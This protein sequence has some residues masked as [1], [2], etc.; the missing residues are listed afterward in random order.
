MRSWKAGEKFGL[1][2]AVRQQGT[3]ER[4]GR[5][6][7]KTWLY[8]CDCGGEKVAI[9]CVV[10]SGKITSCGCVSKKKKDL[11]GMVFGRWT[12]IKE[13]AVRSNSHVCWECRCDCGSV[14]GDVIGIHLF[15]GFSKSCGCLVG[16]SHGMAGTHEYWTWSKMIDRCTNP[17]NKVFEHYGGRG[18]AVCDEWKN[19]FSAFYRDMGRRPSPL[20]SIERIDNNAGYSKDNCKWATRKEQAENRRIRRS[21][22]GRFR[23]IASP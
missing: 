20:L 5:S 19:S 21:A 13:S 7:T 12:V 10:A 4:T 2:T 17:N 1:L 3:A 15:N 23:K 6:P 18:I 16:E 11:T 22:D 8:K 9:P 14:K